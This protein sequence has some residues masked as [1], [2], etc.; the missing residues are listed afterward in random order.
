MIIDDAPRERPDLALLLLAKQDISDMSVA[1]LGER[2]ENL[3][4]EIA[5]AEAAITVR[6]AIKQAADKL[7]K[8]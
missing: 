3:R 4:A 2:I 6:G 5:R 1:D 7:F 8:F